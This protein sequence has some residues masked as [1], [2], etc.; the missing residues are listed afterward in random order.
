MKK[1]IVFFVFG[2]VLLSGINVMAQLSG[3]VGYSYFFDDNPLRTKI[4]QSEFVNSVKS[5]LN[6]KPF[7]FELYAGYSGNFNAFKTIGDRTFQMHSFSLNY[8]LGTTDLEDEN[9]FAG[10]V[11]SLKK[12]RGDFAA[13]DYDQVSGFANGRFPLTETMFIKGAV[14]SSYKKFPSLNNLVHFENFA[15]AQF[16]TFFPTGTGVF[17]EAGAGLMNYT[18]DFTMTATMGG[19]GN[20]KMQGKMS[21]SSATKKFYVTQMRAMAKVSQSIF[22]QTGINFYFLYRDNLKESKGMFIS[23]SYIYSGDDELWDDPYG[24]SSNDIGSEFTQKLPYDMQLK[25][26]AEFSTRHYTNNLSDTLNTTQ[27]VDERFGLWG[28]IT[29]SF[30]EVPFISSIDLGVEYMLINNKSNSGIFNYKNN[31]LQFGVQFNF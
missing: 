11:Y 15:S 13:Y 26:S 1:I 14:Y 16:S 6:Y 7:D 10:A 21:S 29:K 24:F 12:G 22:E 17:L 23:S 4:G 27:R 2:I 19:K 5:D 30:S 31:M 25:L 20:G 28:S 9:V 8:A 18:Y 3:S